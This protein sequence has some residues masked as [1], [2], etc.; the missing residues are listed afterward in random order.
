MNDVTIKPETLEQL[1]ALATASKRRSLTA[2]ELTQTVAADRLREIELP[3]LHEGGE[4]SVVY[5]RPLLAVEVLEFAE[6]QER[7]KGGSTTPDQLRLVA[8]VLMDENGAPLF[9]AGRELEVGKIP[10][11]WFLT[12][13]KALTSEMGVKEG[14]TGEPG[15][16]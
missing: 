12:I 11:Q 4:P 16:G 9:P 8:N 2:L 15:K 14:E 3:A 7:A 6:A 10:A 13:M 1:A 5:H